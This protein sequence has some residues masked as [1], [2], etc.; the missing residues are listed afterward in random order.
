MR[1]RSE[2]RKVRADKRHARESGLA[3]LHDRLG[4][5]GGQL[6]E[7]ALDSGRGGIVF[8]ALDDSKGG[9][10]SEC[11]LEPTERL[12]RCCAAIECFG[13]F[14]VEGEGRGAVFD[15]TFVLWG[16]EVGVACI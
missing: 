10:V 13:V 14:G 7:N 3:S 1:A 16:F 2:R 12:E 5:L 8:E 9:K 15:Y 11:F 4:L 6:G